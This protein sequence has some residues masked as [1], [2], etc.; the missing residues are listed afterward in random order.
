MRLVGAA[1]ELLVAVEAGEGGVSTFIGVAVEFLLCEDIA[2]VLVLHDTSAGMYCWA[3]MRA[4][5]HK[6]DHNGWALD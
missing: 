1:I 2:A 5:G 3:A 4:P 6:R